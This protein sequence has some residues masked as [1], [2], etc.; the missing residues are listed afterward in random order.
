MVMVMVMVMV[1]VMIKVT[2][3]TAKL[4]IWKRR[5]KHECECVRRHPRA[6]DAGGRSAGGDELAV[7]G[8]DL[9][10]AATAAWNRDEVVLFRV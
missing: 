10:A 2:T 4:K 1:I 9:A 7:Q 5:E 3:V 6:P 8:V